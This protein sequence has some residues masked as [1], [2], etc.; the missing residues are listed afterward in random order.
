MTAACAANSVCE[1]L[2]SPGL[3]TGSSVAPL[4]DLVHVHR[5]TQQRCKPSAHRRTPCSMP[6]AQSKISVATFDR[7]QPCRYDGFK[8]HA[9]PGYANMKHPFQFF[10]D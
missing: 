1:W 7:K 5:D 3:L 2:S 4:K 6:A 9:G 10:L 8:I